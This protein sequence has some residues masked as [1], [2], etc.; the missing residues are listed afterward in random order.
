MK[1]IVILGNGGFSKEVAF[2]IDSINKVNKEWNI[3][4]YI[5]NDSSLINTFNGKYKIYNADEWLIENKTELNVAIGMGSPHITSKIISKLKEN[6]NLAFPNL[7]HPNVVADWE[8]ISLG[9]GNIICAGN[10]FTIDIKIGSFNIF[11]LDCTLGHDSIIGDFNVFNPSINISGGVKLGNQN[12]VGTG[13]Q[14]LQFLNI[15]NHNTI[16]AGAVV[17]KDITEEGTYVGLP[18]KKIK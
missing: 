8:L 13:V 17:T 2:L 10:I 5:T 12:L 18:A 15:C 14:I 16:G 9:V 3:L 1:D 11:N 7:I 6:N 4:G